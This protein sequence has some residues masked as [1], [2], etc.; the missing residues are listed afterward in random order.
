[1][2]SGHLPFA[3]DTP[4][5]LFQKIASGSYSF[6]HEIWQ[7]VSRDAQHFINMLLEID[8]ERRATAEQALK[9][10]WIKSVS[11][12][13]PHM[14]RSAKGIT[15]KSIREGTPVEKRTTFTT[16]EEELPPVSR[17]RDSS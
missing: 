17:K 13:D 16:A 5:K 15:K 11:P 10:P 12:I 4:A 2:L 9:H 6:S 1:M 14:Q 3:S 7:L 8:P